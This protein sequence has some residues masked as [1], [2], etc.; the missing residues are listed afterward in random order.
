MLCAWRGN[1]KYQYHNCWLDPTGARTYD[2]EAG[3]LAMHTTDAVYKLEMIVT[4]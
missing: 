3:T 1:S 2:D 4:S